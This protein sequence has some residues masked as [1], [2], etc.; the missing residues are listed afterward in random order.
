M[1]ID[2]G[3]FRNLVDSTTAVTLENLVAASGADGVLLARIMRGLS[4]IHAVNEVGVELYEPN[5]VTRAFTTVK[6]ESGL[7]VL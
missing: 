3:I 1:G 6:G 4:S 2:L 5:K 7:N